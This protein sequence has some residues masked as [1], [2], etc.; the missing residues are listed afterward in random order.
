MTYIDPMLPF[1]LRSA[2]TIFNTV[3]DALHWHL[4]QAGIAFLFHYIDDYI[5]PHPQIPNS[6]NHG[7]I[8]PAGWVCSARNVIVSHKT[9]APATV[10]T[11]L[12]IQIDTCKGELRLPLEKLQ[13]LRDLLEEWKDRKGSTRRELESLIGQ[14]N[15]A[16]KLSGPVGHFCVA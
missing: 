1:G 13:R 6:I 10:V 16:A 5:T 14:L 15:H 12:G 2:P 7:W 11:F 9:E 4:V 3:A 8:Y